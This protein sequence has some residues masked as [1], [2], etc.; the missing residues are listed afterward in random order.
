MLVKKDVT[1]F[2]R[3]SMTNQCLWFIG[4]SSTL[5][6][7]VVSQKPA[8]VAVCLLSVLCLLLPQT[9]SGL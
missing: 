2:A 3:V 8:D 7:G 6:I 9:D 1:C 5:W 4:C